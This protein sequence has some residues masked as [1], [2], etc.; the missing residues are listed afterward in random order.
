LPF[1]LTEKHDFWVFF[2]RKIA[3]ILGEKLTEN[4]NR[5]PGISILATVT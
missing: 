4:L 3:K 1:F 2:L 5:N